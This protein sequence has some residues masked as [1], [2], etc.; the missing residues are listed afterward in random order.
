MP[1]SSLP[2]RQA[3]RGPLR[4]WLQLLRPANVATA[5]AD[6]LAGAALAGALV[7][8]AAALPWLLAATA[9][10]YAGGIVLND[11][12]DRAL[13]AVERPERPIPSGAVA[14]GAAA[15]A[16]ALLLAAGVA[17]S[18][19]A[20]RDAVWLALAIAAAV[21]TYDAWAKHHAVAGP[22]TMG[23]CRALNLLLG[24]AAVPG[25]WLASW[26]FGLIPLF[27]IAGVTIVSRGEVHGSRRAVVGVGFVLVTAVCTV[28][29]GLAAAGGRS[30]PLLSLDRLAT[31]AI[32]AWLAWRVVPALLAAVRDPAPP[33]IGRAV[34]TG[35]LSLVLVDAVIAG[36]YTGIMG[37]PAVLA[38]GLV[39]WLLARLFAVT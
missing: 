24:T 37:I 14:P 27:Y 23:L 17:A 16:G 34:R 32:A 15:L 28:L 8:P 4:A 7:P 12:F 1:T 31:I 36:A 5:P 21:V 39:A 26:W 38:V 19:M 2:S 13:D 6:V 11:V 29:V 22:F 30:A 3:S 9:A 25:A 35:V 20:G 10:L 18:A 33:L